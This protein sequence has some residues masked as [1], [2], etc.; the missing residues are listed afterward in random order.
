MAAQDR[1][2][3]V[4]VTLA[5]YYTP[6]RTAQRFIWKSAASAGSAAIAGHTF[7][8]G[9]QLARSRSRLTRQAEAEA[10]WQ[11]SDR[12]FS[13]VT[14][15]P[16]IPME[17]GGT[18]HRLMEREIDGEALSLKPHEDEIHLG[19]DE[20]SFGH[21]DMVY[22]VTEVRAKKVLGN[23]RRDRIDTLKRFLSRISEI[24]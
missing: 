10:L 13:Q 24:R 5:R 4:C 23:V 17:S 16:G 7:I 19:I 2:G 18:L 14:R 21:Q 15:K 9:K 8:E 12:N 20:H 11:L 22:T 1:I 3:M 6:G